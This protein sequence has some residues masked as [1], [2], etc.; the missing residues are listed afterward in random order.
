M[1]VKLSHENKNYMVD[2]SQPL[3]LSIPLN[4]K[5]PICFH[6]PQPH[7][8]PVAV[9][10]FIGSVEAGS[11][12]NFFNVR[13]NPHGNGTHTESLRHIDSQGKT[14]NQS[15]KTFHFISKLISVEPL[16]KENGDRLLEATQ[17]DF[18]NLNECEA[19]IIRT[20]PN[21]EKKLTQN[22]SNQ[23][24]PYIDVQCMQ[25]IVE[26]GINHLLIDLPSVD[27]EIDGGKLAA[28]H[29]FW[30]GSNRKNCTITEM[31]YVPDKI[32]DGLYLLNLMISPIELDASSSK[33]VLYSMLPIE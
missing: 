4:P 23:N 31:V 13:Y 33:P 6:A 29:L 20:N 24:P 11:P 9:P 22:Y 10:G 1:N 27:R 30:S 21:T 3:D 25:K 8:E 15:L 32:T 7:F 28:H 2:L 16:L 18:D 12:V 26:S 19:L 17:I 14:I 5:G